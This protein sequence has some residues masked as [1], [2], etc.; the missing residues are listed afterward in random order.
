MSPIS[1]II[2]AA[3]MASAFSACRFSE[4]VKEGTIPEISKAIKKGADINGK[5]DGET[6]LICAIRYNKK[7]Y[8]AAM[9]LIDAGA[10]VNAADDTG[11][12]PV[13]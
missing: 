2:I 7:P 6:P 5:T 8:E 4:V 3:V 11:Y 9:L 13:H 1:V 10:D 12:T